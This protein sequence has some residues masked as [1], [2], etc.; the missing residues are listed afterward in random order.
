MA[1][2]CHS[3]GGLGGAVMEMVIAKRSGQSQKGLVPCQST[4]QVRGEDTDDNRSH[5]LPGATLWV[6]LS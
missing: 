1:V 3:Y 5:R 2:V 4:L 6:G